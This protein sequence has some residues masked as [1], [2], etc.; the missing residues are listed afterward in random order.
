[1]CQV[2]PFS[3]L[4]Q[5]FTIYTSIHLVLQKLE[6]I[7][8]ILHELKMVHLEIRSFVTDVANFY[9]KVVHT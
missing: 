7:K 6:E 2:V 1:M 9:H 5:L 8:S 4:Y 3:I